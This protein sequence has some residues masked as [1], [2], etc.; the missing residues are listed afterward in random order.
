MRVPRC[1]AR[2]G[3]SILAKH[4]RVWG[5][6]TLANCPSHYRGRGSSL[7]TLSLPVPGPWFHVPAPP[8]SPGPKPVKQI[9]GDTSQIMPDELPWPEV[10]H[11]W[12]YISHH[13]PNALPLGRSVAVGGATLAAWLLLAIAAGIKAGPGVG[14]QPGAVWAGL[15]HASAC[16]SGLS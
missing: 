5:D 9:L 6:S 2:L 12:P 3:A 13:F 11:P 1:G 15:S 4:H 16:S 10:H 14:A 8:F 7:P